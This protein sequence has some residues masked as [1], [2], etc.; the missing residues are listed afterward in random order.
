[1]IDD[2]TPPAPRFGRIETVELRE[3]WAHEAQ[4]FTP[5]LL[6]NADALGEALDMD[7][8]I[9]TAEHPVGAFSLDLVGTDARTNESVIIENQ[10]ETTD[11]NHLGQLLTYA[12]GVDTVNIVWLAKQFREE[13]RAALDWLN[14]RTDPDTRFFGVEVSVV[15][16]GDSMH[17]PWFRLVVQ[18]NDWKKTV[19]SNNSVRSQEVSDLNLLYA[20]FWDQYIAA[21]HNA[22]LSWTR[23]R[24]APKQNWFD[25]PSGV[26]GAGFVASFSRDGLLSELYFGDPDPAVNDFRFERLQQSRKLLESEY[27]GPLAFEP[28][29]KRKGCR[30]GDR[31][32][33]AITEKDRWPEFINW[34]IDSQRHL[35]AAVDA[36]GGIPRFQ[37]SSREG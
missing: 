34:F 32:P 27:D 35:R 12:A 26:T 16:I 5:W 36:A 37:A 2:S 10:L 25:T 20:E 30:I 24:K 4:E 33:G 11:H 15:R 19:R 6:E 1:M 28:L 22:Q 13:H 9:T 29:D 7:L 3:V 8:E 14:T 18:P 21:M 23:A 17:A 31:S